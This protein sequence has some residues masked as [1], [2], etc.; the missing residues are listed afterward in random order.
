MDRITK[1]K[2]LS[3]FVSTFTIASI[4]FHTI[5]A[6]RE[7][8]VT[9]T[10]IV[11]LFFVAYYFRNI[12]KS[13]S[14]KL[15]YW[16]IS[17]FALLFLVELI[18]VGTGKIFGEYEYGHTLGLIILGVPLLI[19]FNWVLITIGGYQI[20]KRIT[21][22][23]FGISVITML[24]TLCFAYVIEPVAGVLDYWRWESS[25]TPIQSYVAR[26]VIS[27]LVIRSF[28]FLKT[29]YENKFPRYVLVL[30]FTMFIILN[31]VFKLT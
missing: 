22:N 28:L 16:N 24:V 10:P 1:N 17:M 11:L 23:N 21:N 19:G 4:L 26:G 12:L 14:K 5:E 15:I 2:T 27:L 30:E 13:G 31:I 3:S 18:G 9:L 20:A 6:T 7:Y 29:D 8:M 25:A